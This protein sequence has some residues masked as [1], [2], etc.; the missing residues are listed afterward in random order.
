M[1]RPKIDQRPP[2]MTVPP[3]TRILT[4]PIVPTL[5]KLAAP[6]I[7]GFVIMALVTMAELW[8]VGQLGTSAL[9]GL[10]LAFPMVI[11]MQ[12]LSAGSMG[13]VIAATLARSLGAGDHAKAQAIVW[14]ASVVAVFAPVLF[15]LIFLNFSV[16]IFGLVG[17]KGES[18]D[19]AVLYAEALF[20]GVVFVWFFNILCSLLR[21]AGDMKS[22]A[23]AMILTAIIQ[24]FC[25]GG[26]SQG[27]FG[28]PNLGIA[29]IGWGMVIANAIG[30]LIVFL[31]IHSGQST[32]SF[33]Q[34]FFKMNRSI[35]GDFF[36]VGM[37]ASLNPFLSIASIVFLTSLVATFGEQALAGF[38]IGARLEFVLVPVVFGLGAA[39]ISL[40]GSN[41]GAGQV[42]RAEK[43]AWIGGGIAAGVCGGIGL[44]V[45]LFPTS[46]AG[47]FTEDMAVF[48]FAGQYLAVVGPCYFF[49]G[50]GLSLYFA[51]QGAHAVLWPVLAGIGR[52]IIAV[53]LGH[54]VVAQTFSFMALLYCI[55]ASFVAYGVF[56]ALPLLL[57]SWRRAN[58]AHLIGGASN[59][60]IG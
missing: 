57:G 36:K 14:H 50:L 3:L 7:A 41:I 8:F 47:L 12:M 49:F 4:A 2:K 23:R 10:A 37:V 58:R 21:G 27:W 11:L 25:G 52:L 59:S 29:G 45:G 5:L 18:L 48:G 1:T 31:K 32:I 38:G 34:K 56:S 22:P 42:K 16:Q 13:G 20:T 33:E 30:A 46:W 43:I 53:G 39:M 35:W 51:S 28:M 6:N 55:A 9:A 44:W 26:L 17:G 24:I 60:T 19:Q 54:L 40:V 15:S